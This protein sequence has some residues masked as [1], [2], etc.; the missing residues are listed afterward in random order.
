MR[1]LVISDVHANWEALEAVLHAAKGV[2][3]RVACLGDLVGYGPDPNR[4]VEW[5]REN[6]SFAVRGNH[7]RACVDLIGLDKFRDIAIDSAL[8][9]NRTLTE[10]NSLY[11][12]NLPQGPLSIEDFGIAHGSPRDEDEYLVEVEDATEAF[13]F[14][15]SRIT[16]FGHTHLQGGFQARRGRVTGLKIQATPE[17]LDFQ[18]DTD[19]LINPGS[20]G[21]PRDRDP[22]AAFALYTPGEGYLTYGRAGYRIAATQKK[23]RAAGLPSVLADRLAVGQ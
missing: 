9:T 7:D 10:Q 22:L 16:F 20:V 6:V 19:Y 4:V 8:W 21:Q 18:P 2:Y 11:L 3:D 23:I 12:R 1:Y 15:E 17:E 13:A 14:A 5:A